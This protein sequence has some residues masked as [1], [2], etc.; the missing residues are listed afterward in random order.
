MRPIRQIINPKIKNSS[1]LERFIK[2]YGDKATLAATDDEIRKGLKSFYNDLMNG[3]IQQE[4]Y[5]PYLRS[6]PRLLQLAIQDSEIRMTKEYII[7]SS[8]QFAN[9]NGLPA[10]NHPMYRATWDSCNSRYRAYGIINN[11]LIQFMNTGNMAFLTSI[12]VQIQDPMN[13][14]F[15]PEL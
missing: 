5:E 2:K 6:D 4:K 3:Y 1:F 8:L 10:A 7:V 12:S 15:R 14:Q 11:C 13:R 9:A